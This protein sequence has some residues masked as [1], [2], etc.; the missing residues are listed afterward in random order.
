M[1]RPSQRH[2][3]PENLDPRLRAGLVGH[4]IGGVSGLTWQDRSGYG[5]H[6]TL[7]N[8]PIRTLGEGG[9]REAL[10]FDGSDDYV[11][12]GTALSPLLAGEN[13]AAAWIRMT[14][15]ALS[16]VV[17]CSNGSGGYLNLEVN[18]TAGRISTLRRDYGVGYSGTRPMN[19]NEWYHVAA[20][21]SGGPGAWT[22][23][24]FINGQIDFTTSAAANA[25]AATYSTSIGRLSPT[26]HHF[27]GI[28]DDVRI[29]SRALSDAEIAILAQPSFLPV[30]PRRWFIGPNSITTQ[31]T[32]AVSTWTAPPATARTRY[33]VPASAALSTWVAPSASAQLNRRRSI[34]VPCSVASYSIPTSS[35]SYQIEVS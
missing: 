5:N 18:R 13:T 14:G 6:G 26:L 25:T 10:S 20:R 24:L 16:Q 33:T 1:I 31:A 7:T 35:T 19:L 12:A 2:F 17:A 28:I 34:S 22:Y 21:I 32:A 27:P 9:K 4:W 29:Y 8:G 11:D 15:T 23:A 3:A 30:V